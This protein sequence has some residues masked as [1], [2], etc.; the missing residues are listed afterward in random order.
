MKLLEFI[1]EHDN[2]KELLQ[3]SPYNL[4]VKEKDDYTLLKYNQLESDFSNEI[5][6]ECRGII[7]NKDNKIVCYPFHKFFNYG[8]QYA[9]FID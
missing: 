7:L 6:R 9:D 3:Q 1:N 4:I 5:V 8:E 2:W